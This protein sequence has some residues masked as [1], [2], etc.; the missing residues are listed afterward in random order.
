MN[1]REEKWGAVMTEPGGLLAGPPWE[2]QGQRPSRSRKVSF[3]R[4]ASKFCEFSRLKGRSWEKASGAVRLRILDANVI[5][6]R[7][8]GNKYAGHK[9]GLLKA[10]A[11][12][13]TQWCL[14]GHPIYR[15]G[16]GSQT[17]KW[18]STCWRGPLSHYP[19][20]TTTTGRSQQVCL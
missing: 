10:S 16:R 14:P 17:L 3:S 20:P 13:A 8:G 12:P 19:L 2:F 1:S 5:V 9:G 15:I 11:A 7:S 6:C 4:R 18:C